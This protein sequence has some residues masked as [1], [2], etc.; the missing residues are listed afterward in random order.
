[1]SVF[2]TQGT[3]NTSLNY[4][5]MAIPDLIVSISYVMLYIGSVEY[6]SSQVPYFMK[7]LTVGVAYSSLFLSGA[8][9]LVLS[10]PF[11]SHNLS[12]NWGASCGFW[13]GLLL[14]IAEATMCVILI[15]L[16][17]WYKKRKRQDVLPNEHVYAERYYSVS[18]DI[19]V[20]KVPV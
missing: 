6:F 19:I 14:M 1:M 15:V 11:K 17:K 13:Y 7:D 4:Y 3:V 10:I 16:T 5:W 9:W 20:N 2:S 12:Y 18:H 8:V